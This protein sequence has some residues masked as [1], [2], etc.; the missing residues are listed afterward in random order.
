MYRVT[1][2]GLLMHS[3][4]ILYAKRFTLAAVLSQTPTP[5]YNQSPQAEH[6]RKKQP[7]RCRHSWPK[8]PPGQNNKVSASLTPQTPILTI[9]WYCSINT[10]TAQHLQ[11]QGLHAGSHVPS[12]CIIQCTPASPIMVYCD[13]GGHYQLPSPA[14]L[15]AETQATPDS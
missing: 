15:A 8:Q 14:A 9:R 13:A 7:T 12:L 5:P 11:M 10:L 3:S 2:V 6:D 1:D 4:I